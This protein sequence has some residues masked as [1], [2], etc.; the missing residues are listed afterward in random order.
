MKQMKRE[1]LFKGKSLHEGGKWIYDASYDFK[2]AFGTFIG[3]TAVAPISACLSTGLHNDE[4][5]EVYEGDILI[6]H[7]S[8]M[9]VEVV[10]VWNR[11]EAKFQADRLIGGKFSDLSRSKVSNWTPNGN[12]Y[13]KNVVTWDRHKGF[14]PVEQSDAE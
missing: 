12:I 11:D 2:G 9:D 3:D 10:I 13:D 8:T 6:V 1:W 4:G 5:K 7:A 14:V